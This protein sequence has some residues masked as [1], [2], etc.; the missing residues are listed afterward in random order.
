VGPDRLAAAL[1]ARDISKSF[2]GTR[3]LDRASLEVRPAEVHGLLGENG[4]GKSTLIRILAGYH[5]P[6]PGGRLLVGGRE[7]ALPPRA[8]EPRALGMSFVHQD[9]GLI[10]S[11]SV[12]ENVRLDELATTRRR[13][14]SPRRERQAAAE[15]LAR[16][17]LDID[18]RLRVDEL[19][20]VARALVA[21]VR[22]M[23]G[24]P[25]AGGLLVLDEPGA[26]L[27]RP[28]RERLF[29]LARAVADSGSSVLLVSH[30]VGE[31]AAA[32][33]RITVLRDGR[34]V[35]TIDPAVAG[36]EELVRMIVGHP[37]V[38]VG[39]GPAAGGRRNG[40]V[41]ISGLSGEVVRD[42]SIELERGEVLGLSG[43]AGSG[44][45]EVPYLLF[46][47]RPCRAGTLL[48]EREHELTAMTP[49]RALRAGISL[50]PGDR[51]REGGVG[52]LSVASNVTLPVL[53]RYATRLRLERAR[54]TR[55]AARLLGEHDVR[56]P[57]PRLP[58]EAL[59][60]GN[61]QRALLAKAVQASPPLLLLDEPT[62]GVDVG[63]R[64]AI[65]AA[66]RDLA[67]DGVTVVC[68][69]GDHEQ[70]ELL[71]DR[72]LIFAGGM[73]VRELVGADVSRERIAE[74]CHA[75]R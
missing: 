69:S 46:G 4:S 22:A 12:A 15:A 74:Q 33:D 58:F 19:T 62:R 57:D 28:E 6:D 70:L 55:A 36:S 35:G 60:G 39:A 44:F 49:E 23:E 27:P 2:G 25:E 10:P 21:I 54:L 31:A 72:V 67:R 68:A 53:E 37:L 48:L 71:C 13:R 42:L 40:A 5:A 30:D 73:V 1:E 32:C 34:N 64:H 50:L 65:A 41:R 56:P 24:L 20:P 61:Q 7:V 47:G 51:A 63:A 26:F 11:L 3:A 14:L 75:A 8:G 17:G 45:E 29:A 9:L 52:S 43:L 16:F 38:P 18:A 59:S 66:I